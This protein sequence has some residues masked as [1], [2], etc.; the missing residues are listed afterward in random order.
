MHGRFT[1]YRGISMD[2]ETFLKCRKYRK[3]I[4]KFFTN[5][6]KYFNSFTTDIDG[7]YDYAYPLFGMPGNIPVIIAGEATPNDVYFAFS[8][9]L[10]GRHIDRT[11]GELNISNINELENLRVVKMGKEIA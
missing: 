9:Y 11:P 6:N 7:T 1:V 5:K 4:S 8:A 10:M 2:N 3:E